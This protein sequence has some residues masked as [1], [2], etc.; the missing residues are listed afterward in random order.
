MHTHTYSFTSPPGLLPFL[1]IWHW[2]AMFASHWELCV[3]VCSKRTFAAK[4]ARI[5]GVTSEPCVNLYLHI[6]L[7][8][9]DL[10]ISE[11]WATVIFHQS[12]KSASIFV[13]VCIHIETKTHLFRA[14]VVFDPLTVAWCSHLY[15]QGCS[16]CPIW[17]LLPEKKKH[18]KNY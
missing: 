16:F 15:R 14:V 13:C 10:L 5:P 2:G 6:D 1:F 17:P 4:N 9:W 8:L 11:Q 3:V 18:L 7:W 12:A